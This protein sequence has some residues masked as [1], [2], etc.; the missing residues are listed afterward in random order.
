M[1]LLVVDDNRS[2]LAAVRLLAE[3]KFD[4]VLTTTSPSRI[5]Q[6]LREEKPSCVLLD[7]NVSSPVT[8]GNEGLYWLSEIRRLSPTTPVVLFTA[9][10]EIELA[11]QGLK[12]GA[13]DF[14]TKPWN[15]ARLLQ[16]LLHAATQTGNQPH[17]RSDDSPV[18]PPATTLEQMERRMISEALADNGG[19]LSATAERLGITRQTLYNKL[20]RHHLQ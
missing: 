6:L 20:K 7:M 15:N 8:N 5:P 13:A 19:N 4:R 1:T 10:A 14:V 3:I 12:D 17:N 2:V 18:N 16:T 11:V 9:Y